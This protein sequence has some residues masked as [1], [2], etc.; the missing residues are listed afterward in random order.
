MEEQKI[1]FKLIQTKFLPIILKIKSVSHP[2]DLERR[3]SHQGSMGCLKLSYKPSWPSSSVG[4][5]PEWL[6]GQAQH[7]PRRARWGGPGAAWALG[8]SLASLCD[9]NPWSR[10]LIV[11]SLVKWTTIQKVQWQEP[12]GKSFMLCYI[13]FISFISFLFENLYLS[14]ASWGMWWKLS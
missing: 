4:E 13:S 14:R 5:F 6:P 7:R 12:F 11:Q 2:S 10:E 3:V 8:G 9:V 1:R